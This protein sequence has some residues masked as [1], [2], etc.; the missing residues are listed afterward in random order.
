LA[1]AALLAPAAALCTVVAVDLGFLATFV[2]ATFAAGAVA[3]AARRSGDR[4]L[5]IRRRPLLIDV[6]MLGILLMTRMLG[7]VPTSAA[8]VFM[9]DGGLF[10]DLGHQG[11]AVDE[12]EG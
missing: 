7:S 1:A 6:A 8:A 9:S 10:D 12:R 11:G 4:A 2:A 5:A 3:W